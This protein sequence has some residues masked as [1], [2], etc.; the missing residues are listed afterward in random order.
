MH[1]KNYDEARARSKADNKQN[2]RQGT[3]AEDRHKFPAIFLHKINPQNIQRNILRFAL[4]ILE[5]TA[6]M[7]EVL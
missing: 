7:T 3:R 2:E 1:S 5:T 4:D 6:K